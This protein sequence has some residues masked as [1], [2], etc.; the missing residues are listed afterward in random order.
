MLK[1]Y[2]QNVIIYLCYNIP[3]ITAE[4]VATKIVN[5]KNIAADRKQSLPV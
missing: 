3:L 2:K 1:T 5:L 4:K